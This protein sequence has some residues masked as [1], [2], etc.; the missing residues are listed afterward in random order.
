MRY[1]ASSYGA[2]LQPMRDRILISVIVPLLASCA[3]TPLSTDTVR[4]GDTAIAIARKACGLVD[5]ERYHWTAFLHDGVWDVRQYWQNQSGSCGYEGTKIRASDGVA[6][7]CM[8]C[9][10]G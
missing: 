9:A 2:N 1:Q 7:P 4:D 10:S 5:Y 6:G 8:N 3:E